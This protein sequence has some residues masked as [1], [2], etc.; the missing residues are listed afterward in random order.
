M[1]GVIAHPEMAWTIPEMGGHFRDG[2]THLIS[3]LGDGQIHLRDG[4]SISG[5]A[6]HLG[7]GEIHLRMSVISE[8]GRIISG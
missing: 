1:G 2:P 4:R 3:H 7:D 8:I 6:G 5:M